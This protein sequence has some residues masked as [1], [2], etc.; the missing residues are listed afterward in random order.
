MAVTIVAVVVFVLRPLDLTE[1]QQIPGGVLRVTV[2]DASGA[3]LVGATVT[4][5]GLDAGNKSVVV[6]PAT[7]SDQG[8]AVLPGLV[9]GRYTVEAAF[10]G[11]ETR[12]LPDVRVRNGENRQ[13]LLLPIE[14]LKDTVVVEQDRQAA[15]VDPRGP[16]FG[17]T[18]TREQLDALSD[19]PEILRQQL[20]DMAGPGA[21]IKVDSFEGGALPPK[22]QIRSIRISRDQFAAENH[23]AGGTQIEIITQPG[24]G[25]VRLN[26][27][28]RM[29]SSGLGGRS[30]FT[31][32]RGSERNRTY[33]FGGFGTLIKDK[34]SFNVFGIVTDSYDTPN[35]NVALVGRT[36]SEALAIRTPREN[37]R[38]N[39]QVDYALTLDQTLRFGLNVN[40]NDDRNLGIGA[41]DEEERA[42]ATRN[43]T[44]TIRAQHM[45][46]LGRRAFT[47]SRLQYSWSDS[48]SRSVVETPTIRVNDAFTRGGAQIAG[49]QHS[50]AVGLGSDLDYVRGMHTIRAGMQIDAASWRS[51]DSSNYLGTYTFE[52]LDAFREGRPRSYTRRLGD[53]NIRYQNVQAGVYVQDDAR[54]RR[55]LT[56]S[57]GMRYEAQTHVGDHSNLAPRIG[58]TWSP[59]AGGQ[60][61]LRSSWGLFYDWM[62]TNTYEQSLRVDGFRQQELNVIDPV[63]PGFADAIGGVPPINRYVLGDD[64][65]LPRSNRVSVGIDQRLARMVNTTA[66]YSFTRGAALAR[67]LNLNAPVESVRPDP[68]F[69]NIVEVVSD[70]NSRLHQLQL[71]LTANPGA[72]LPAF[73]APRIRWRRTT[74]FLNYT[75]AKLESNTEGAF[76]IAPTGR[77][78]DDWGP[79]AEDVRHRVNVQL[80]NQIVRNL[81][82]GFNLTA[83]S[84]TPYSIRTGLDGNGDLVF[85]DRPPGVARNTERA[86]TQWTVNMFGGYALAL[87]KP[88]SGPPGVTAIAGGG[89]ATVQNYEQ[90]PRYVVQF[91]I[92]ARNLTNHPNYVGYS[93]VLTSPFFGR[94][95]TV[96]GT[97]KI[98]AGI[99]FAF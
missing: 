44:S 27:G 78:A 33:F 29:R 53:P 11:F 40:R 49:G 2:V 31:P 6:A 16:S 26:G 57:A 18:L 17:T 91:F 9:A 86:A 96:T 5:A 52:S 92:E 95:T 60:T 97:R 89:V 65:R 14:G 22:A 15:A 13:V 82:V 19:D 59:F 32:T 41:F 88:V 84:G 62:A 37:I 38:V 4:V 98:D 39:A 73:N 12:R 69:G 23:S 94:A 24:L 36:R 93:G 99:N 85:N 10:P 81:F 70:A 50:R 45:G 90:P 67:G 51:N 1:A 25:P 80:N 63:Y 3:V 58:A 68:L 54:V 47:R 48:D 76:A 83:S 56:L 87:G 30:P 66:T 20:Q 72:L 28:L 7:T 75:L 55:S 21:V 79:S 74:L 71:N 34:A 35:I 77:L 46:P 61:T 64:F 42:Y 8:V 43:H